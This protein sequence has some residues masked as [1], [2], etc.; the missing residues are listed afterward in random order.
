M[1]PRGTAPLL[2]RAVL[3]T[4][5]VA[6]G[7]TPKVRCGD[8]EAP[9][10]VEDGAAHLFQ[11]DAI[12]DIDLF[13]EA[14]ERA[15]L[16]DDVARGP[17]V[18]ADLVIGG[19]RWGVGLRL[20]GDS[21]FR[22]IEAKAAFKID[23]HEFHE[24]ASFHG[25][26][27]LTLNNMI[28][29]ASML[30]ESITYRL[31][32]ALELPAPRHGYA[33]VAVNGEPYGLY[34]VVET[35]D[36]Q[37]IERWWEDD[38]GNLYEGGYSADVFGDHPELF[39]VEE[40]GEPNDMSD[41]WELAAAVDATDSD[42]WLTMLETW[43]DAD[44]LLTLWAAE[45]YVANPDAYP[46][47]GNNFL[48]YREPVDNR[49][50]MIPWGTDQALVVDLDVSDVPPGGGYLMQGCLESTDCR[51]RL[52]AKV[53]EVADVADA[54][55]LPGFAQAQRDRIRYTSRNDPRAEFNSTQIWGAQRGVVRF[56]RSRSKEVRD[57]LER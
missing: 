42:D 23:V 43:F 11:H 5:L 34:G 55:D 47:A 52:E 49:W 24:N 22:P 4:A 19:E 41:L 14:K 45:L 30:S 21:S 51:T 13:I 17:D 37:F 3:A 35:L 31:M 15:L 28:Q 12:V 1:D 38:G 26:R 44:A 20:K 10:P 2:T 57:Q 48:L 16:A 33:C 39:E 46:T 50:W 6:L 27:R 53:L 32:E 54:I 40:R 9:P 8:D 56:V 25:L 29:D 18:P 7:C 36:E